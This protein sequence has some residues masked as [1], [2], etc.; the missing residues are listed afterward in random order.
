MPHFDHFPCPGEIDP[1]DMCPRK[2]ILGQKW[3]FWGQASYLFWEEAKVV[4]PTDQKPTIRI[5]LLFKHGTKWI[6]KANIWPKMT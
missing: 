2:H 4:V 5:V 1:H 6:K 3:P